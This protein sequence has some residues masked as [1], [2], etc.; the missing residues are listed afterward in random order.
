MQARRGVNAC[1]PCREGSL[2]RLKG[3]QCPSIAERTNRQP[4]L[5]KPRGDAHSSLRSSAK[6]VQIT[7]IF[8]AAQHP[9]HCVGSNFDSILSLASQSYRSGKPR[10]ALMPTVNYNGSPYDSLQRH[11]VTRSSE[12]QLPRHRHPLR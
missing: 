10:N 6:L 3:S 12:K 7:A 8:H 2:N 11:R 4:R 1:H 9:I 5:P